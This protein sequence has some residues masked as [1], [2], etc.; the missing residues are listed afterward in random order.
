M[1]KSRTDSKKK[2]KPEPDHGSRGYLRWSR[3]PA[4]GLF[5][6]LPLWMLYEGLR[7]WLSPTERN[8][9][10]VLLLQELD[11]LGWQGLMVVRI[12]FLLMIF[13]AARSLI[14]RDVPWLRVAAVV[15][16][17]GTV[18]GL[19]L[20]P[21]AAAMTSSAVR[22]LDAG[23]VVPSSGGLLNDLVG[24]LGAGIFEELVFRLGLISILV[25]VGVRAIRA[26][27]LPKWIVGWVAVIGSALA[28]SWFHHLC[29]EPFDRTRFM[30]RT[31]AGILLGL[32]MWFRGYGVCVYAHTFYDVH[33]YLTQSD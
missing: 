12:C 20:G 2:T 25:W 10:E 26:W 17:E 9:A 14:R 7:L 24:S 32:L 22:L 3:D 11:R 19:L 29:G 4:L 16:L 6:V 28:F 13:V 1:A 8:G 15:A 18:Y 5:A 30:F 21:S 33:Y 31:M 23:A 27:S